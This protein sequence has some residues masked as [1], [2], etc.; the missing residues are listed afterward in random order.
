MREDYRHDDSVC[1]KCTDK[2]KN[3]GICTNQKYLGRPCLK[4]SNSSLVLSNLR[5]VLFRR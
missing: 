1:V 5:K 3:V 2:D 4:H